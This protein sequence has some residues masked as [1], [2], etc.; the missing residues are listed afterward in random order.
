MK[1]T[2]TLKMY[3]LKHFL[4]YMGLAAIAGAVI[5]ALANATAWSDGLI[6][7]AGLLIGLAIS[8]IA[9]REGLFGV[10]RNR[11]RAA[12]RRHA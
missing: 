5:G 7:A 6:Y 4:F 8:A 11:R 1:T 10:S 9:M 2:E 12:R 3:T